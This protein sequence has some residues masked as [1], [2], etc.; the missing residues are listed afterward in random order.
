M[1]QLRKH[2]QESE[3]GRNQWC[4]QTSWCCDQ[5]EPNP[6]ASSSRQSTHLRILS[7]AGQGAGALIHQLPP[8]VEAA[9][10]E[11]RGRSFSS[12]LWLAG[13]MRL[14]DQFLKKTSF[15]A[16]LLEQI[17][18]AGGVAKLPQLGIGKEM[19]ITK[20]AWCG[21][22]CRDSCPM[23]SCPGMGCRVSSCSDG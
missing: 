14:M 8:L 23:Q 20:E 18:A 19:L 9:P 6:L 5:A 22:G 17:R 13:K 15:Q 2:Q 21:E 16:H 12:S 10:E 3:E 1:K 4:Y 7:P 11:M